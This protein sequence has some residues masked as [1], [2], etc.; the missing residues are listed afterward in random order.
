[1]AFEPNPGEEPD[2]KQPVAHGV[3][4]V[5]WT[6]SFRFW[7]QLD[8]FGV[9]NSEAKWFVSLLEKLKDLS[10]REKDRFLRDPKL[11]EDWRYHTINWGQRNIPIQRADLD[12][13]D[14]NYRDN[15]DEFPLV[16]F[17]VSQALGRIVGFWDEKDIFNIVLLDP[18]HNIQPSKDYDYKLDPT[19][20]LRCQYSSLLYKIHQ[21]Q[22]GAEC[23]NPRCT[24]KAKLETIETTNPYQN[25]L[26][27]YI[28]DEDLGRAANLKDEGW[29]ESSRDIFEYGLN[30]LES[31][32]GK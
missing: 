5:Y 1:M 14:E 8:Y 23:E 11:K 4:P 29:V 9:G 26:I 16:Q 22:H 31:E 12:W 30:Y 21:I 2:D 7:R 18:L 10:G 19:N 27:H 6:F 20:P 24:Y 3:G 17:Q 32:K 28:D 15:S 13:I 25:V